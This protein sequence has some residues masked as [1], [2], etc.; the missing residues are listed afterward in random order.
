MLW[1]SVYK[2]LCKHM[3][4]LLLGIYTGMELLGHMVTLRINC[5]KKYLNALHNGYT[6]LCSHQKNIRVPISPYHCLL[7]KM[8]NDPSGYE[9]LPHCGLIYIFLITNNVEQF[10]MCLLA[11]YVSSMEKCPFLNTCLFIKLEQSFLFNIY[12]T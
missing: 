6:I 3:L 5:L 2:Y 11:I 4:S 7:K 1:T 10:F 12:Y 8:Y 9:A